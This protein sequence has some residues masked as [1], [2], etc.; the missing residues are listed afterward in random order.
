MS[1]GNV[2]VSDALW[3]LK[4]EALKQAVDRLVQAIN[5][6]ATFD[7]LDQRRGNPLWRYV[8]N[9]R[10]EGSDGEKDDTA[11]YLYYVQKY[12]VIPDGV[13]PEILKERQKKWNIQQ[14][15]WEEIA[16]LKS[17][18]LAKSKVK[19]EAPAAAAPRRLLPRLGRGHAPP[20]RA[21]SA[22]VTH[23]LLHLDSDGEAQSESKEDQEKR[24]A[25]TEGRARNSSSSSGGFV[26]WLL[27]RCRGVPQEHIRN[28]Y[29][30]ATKTRK[31]RKEAPSTAY[32]R[33][34][35][36]YAL[37][38]ISS[39]YHIPS[40]SSRVPHPVHDFVRQHVL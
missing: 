32:N 23:S 1:S 5:H 11:Q 15:S 40:S 19:S 16:D 13:G 18:L 3:A 29:Q 31:S 26:D 2:S 30:I 33:A 35:A 8:R 21:E 10:M 36:Q 7:V 34:R 28:L 25:G 27:S 14:Y 39:R 22:L 12:I 24:Q 4:D 37:L 38:H 20:A 6:K 9:Y 17:R